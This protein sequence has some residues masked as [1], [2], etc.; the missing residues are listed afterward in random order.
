MSK[1]KMTERDICTKFITPAIVGAGWDLH[2]QIREES[3]ITDG[4]NHCTGNSCYTRG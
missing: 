4:K 2:R 1:Q 3:Q